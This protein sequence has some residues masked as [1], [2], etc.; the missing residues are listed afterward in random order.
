MNKM[1][2]PD[3]QKYQETSAQLVLNCKHSLGAILD[4]FNTHK[5]RIHNQMKTFEDLLRTYED[6]IEDGTYCRSDFKDLQE[7]LGTQAIINAHYDSLLETYEN[8]FRFLSNGSGE[9]LSKVKGEIHDLRIKLVEL[10]QKY[11]VLTKRIGTKVKTA[12]E[13]VEAMKIDKQEL[14]KGIKEK[15]DSMSTD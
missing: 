9:D 6:R 5:P 15:L 4:D 2:V 10:D 8:N 14:D 1:V 7:T 12:T 11:E 3:S 13:W